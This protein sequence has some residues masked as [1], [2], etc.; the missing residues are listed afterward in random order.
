[1]LWYRSSTNQHSKSSSLD[2]HVSSTNI[3]PVTEYC[4]EHFAQHLIPTRY[5][6]GKENQVG[7]E[8][9]SWQRYRF[10]MHYAEGSL[11]T[12]LIVTMFID[13]KSIYLHR[14]SKAHTSVDNTLPALQKS[15]TPQSPSSSS[16]SPAPLPAASTT[17]S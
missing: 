1:M 13:R 14:S 16:P 17:P 8:T 10:F 7:G 9:E 2:L 5:Q 4:S 11:M 12:L 3:N 15:A 6:P